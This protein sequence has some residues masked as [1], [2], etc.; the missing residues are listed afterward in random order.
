MGD[1]ERRLF[2][3]AAVSGACSDLASR[4]SWCVAGVIL[5]LNV[6][7]LGPLFWIVPAIGLVLCATLVHPWAL[8]LALGRPRRGHRHPPR[9]AHN[10]PHARPVGARATASTRA[11]GCSSRAGPRDRRRPHRRRQP[12]DPAAAA[13]RGRDPARADSRAGPDRTFQREGAALPAADEPAPQARQ[14]NP[15][16]PRRPPP[17]PRRPR[18]PPPTPRCPR[19]PPTPPARGPPHRPRA[20]PRHRP[21]PRATPRRA[22]PP[23]PPR[24]R[25]IPPATMP[26]GSRL[27]PSAVVIYSAA[28]LRN[29]AFPLIVLI[30]IWVFGGATDNR[31]F[32][33]C[34]ALRRDRLRRSRVI[35]GAMRYQSTTCPPLR[36]TRWV[37][38]PHR[39]LQHEGH[40]HPARPDRGDG[41]PPGPAAAGCS[42]SSRCDVPTGAT[43]K[44][45]EISLPALTQE[46]VAELRRPA[47]RRRPPWP[48]RRSASARA[49]G[50][51]D[52]SSAIAALTAGQLGILLP[53]AR[54]RWPDHPAALRREAGRGGDPLAAAHRHRGRPRRGRAAR[55]LAWLLSTVGAIVTF[56]GFTVTRDGDRLRISRGLVQRSEA[57]VRG[58]RR[59]AR[60]PRCAGRRRGGSAAGR[61]RG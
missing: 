24:H 49:A 58:A 54:R 20:R 32:L 48:R 4:R 27:R 23:I 52:A 40:R 18:A 44:G 7:V 36:T 25:L 9:R 26:D 15:R 8:A 56:G 57:T 1:P 3:I 55:L 11:A 17:T 41:R 60:W 29:A 34:A 38:P 6:D 16:C 46:A 51:P 14:P 10:P 61:R 50:S 30:A 45:G 22:S 13:D 37:P 5:T 42:G 2:P 53:G 33:R 39:H 35:A 31:G 28:A 12:H 59:P 21:A 47:R 43:S 19:A